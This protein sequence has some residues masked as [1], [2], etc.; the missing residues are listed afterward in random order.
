MIRILSRLFRLR[1]ALL[2]GV[3]AMGGYLLYPAAP[4]TARMVA[5][6]IGVGVL[7]AGASALNQLQER[8]LDQLMART[9]HRP[10]PRGDLT[11]ATAAVIGGG[12]VLAGLMIVGAAGGLLPVLLGAFALL[13]YLGVYTPLKRRTASA[14]AFGA[15]SGALPPVIGWSVAGGD[16]AD[17]RVMLVAGLLY[18]WQ[19]PHFWLIQRR[20]ADDFLRAGIPL[21]GTRTGGACST[22]HCRLWILSLGAAAM[23]LPAFGIIERH[24]A[25]WYAV[26]ILSLMLVS[27]FRTTA[28]LYSYLN[29]FPLMVTLALCA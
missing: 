4:G 11:P 9:R 17:Y 10:L 1:L 24:V 16:P 28:A 21:F 19:I 27:R 6:L 15:L 22:A 3:V 8:D 26:F 7:A 2:N 14:L 20:H 29:L 5:A 23:L 25:F 12:C 13:W 18:L